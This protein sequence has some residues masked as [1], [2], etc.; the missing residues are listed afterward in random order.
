MSIKITIIGCI[1]LF[2]LV[3]IS[4]ASAIEI[5]TDLEKK[6]SPLYRIRTRNA[7]GEKLT[8]IIETI[9]TKFLGDR[10]FFIPYLQNRYQHRGLFDKEWTDQI[11]CTFFGDGTTCYPHDDHTCYECWTTGPTC[12]GHCPTKGPLFD[13]C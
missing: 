8:N 5:N 3:A 11:Q 10:I 4:L 9:K 6:E 1:L 2:M 13:D 7:I 12:D